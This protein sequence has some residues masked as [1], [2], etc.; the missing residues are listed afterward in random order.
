[1]S[2]ISIAF[3][4]RIWRSPANYVVSRRSLIRLSET[5][6]S[7][8]TLL[9]DEEEWEVMLI[10]RNGLWNRASFDTSEPKNGCA[11]VESKSR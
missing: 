4:S 1:V 6:Q 10:E 11:V 9:Q 5:I 7:I 8:L 3:Q 2:Q